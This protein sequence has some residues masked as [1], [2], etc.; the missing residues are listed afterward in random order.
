[1]PLL[2]AILALAE[3]DLGVT[4]DPSLM[5]TDSMNPSVGFPVLSQL[6]GHPENRHRIGHRRFHVWRCAV[7]SH[8][9]YPLYPRRR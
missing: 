3:G 4:F 7:Q 2:L 1:L 5:A 6:A 9:R 8:P